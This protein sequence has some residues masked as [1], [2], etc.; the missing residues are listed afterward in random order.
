MCV[1]LLIF[2]IPYSSV[3]TLSASVFVTLFCCSVDSL[4]FIA[5]MELKTFV[6]LFCCLVSGREVL[7]LAMQCTLHRVGLNYLKTSDNRVSKT[8]GNLLEFTVPR[9]NFCVR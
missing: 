2:K 8:P 5:L 3:L 6:V 4:C 7:C 9:G 1:L